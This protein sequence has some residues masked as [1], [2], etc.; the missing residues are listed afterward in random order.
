MKSVSSMRALVSE[1]NGIA[2]GPGSLMR[3]MVS[4]MAR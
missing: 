1:W 4:S 3:M 2:L